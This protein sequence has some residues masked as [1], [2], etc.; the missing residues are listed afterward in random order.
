MDIAKNDYR[1]WLRSERI[2][3]EEDYE[4]VAH[5]VEIRTAVFQDDNPESLRERIVADCVFEL[6]PRCKEILTMFYYE[7][8]KLDNIMMELPTF[9][10]KDA[11]KTAKNK[12]YTTL[13]NNVLQ[14]YKIAM[15]NY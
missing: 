8:K 15:I 14:Q 9:T 2:T 13:K 11:L 12:C 6:P 3:L 10:S 1:D 4:S 5:S 7:G